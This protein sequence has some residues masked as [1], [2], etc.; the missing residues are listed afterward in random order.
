MHRA[1]RTTRCVTAGLLLTLL[2]TAAL[3]WHD[4]G[5]HEVLGRDENATIVK[6]DQPS[7]GAVLEIAAL[8]TSGQP[9][10]MQPL[11][12]LI[13]HLFWPAIGRSASLLRFLSSA[14]GLLAIVVTFKLGEALFGRE[15]GLVGALLTALLPLQLRYA[16]IARPYALLVLFSLVSSYCL[17]RAL[18]TNRLG[19]WAGFVLA[20]T[21]GFYTHYNTLFVVAAEGLLTAVAWLTALV[22]VLKHKEAP[23]RLVRP[24]LGFAVM[25]LL[26]LPGLMRLFRMS[27]VGLG[28]EVVAEGGVMLTLTVPFLRHFMY[29][30]GLVTRWLQNLLALLMVV[31]LAATLLRRRFLAALFAVLWLAV[32]FATLAA[33]HS[34]RP[35]EERYVIFVMPVA[36]LLV[37]Q[38]VVALGEWL[39][40]LT[41]RR[42]R[43][44]VCWSITLVLTVGL[45]WILAGRVGAYYAGNRAADRLDQT[46][47]V[48]EDWAQPGD[49]IVVSPRF[50]L[51]P[52]TVPGVEVLYLTRHPSFD[53]L[54]ALA[55]RHERIWILYTSCPWDT[56]FREPI[57]QWVG[58]RLDQFVQVP[59]KS[60]CALAFGARASADTESTLKDRIAVL[61]ELARNSAGEGE[62]RM[63]YGLLADSYLEMADLYASRNEHTLS[64]EYRQM[65]TTIRAA[66]P[67]P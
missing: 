23:G 22:A 24:V 55:S 17:V 2:L 34:P 46:L 38:A 57:D 37:G 67:S 19:H 48:V 30:S 66:H 61:E 39:S 36:F 56:R 54:D 45:A 21:L 31:G 20:A 3:V 8:N 15:A 10:N 63:R 7:L 60:V 16:Q 40:F 41:Q 33:I 44:A 58:A 6:L 29:E 4:L 35:F 9:G 53:E 64:M 1:T 43:P 59:I 13:Q 47:V 32:P 14:A 51:R 11:Y 25:G 27:W 18:S 62:A 49:V 12:F 5:V 28:E 65:A 50:F 26:Y 52:L 42:H